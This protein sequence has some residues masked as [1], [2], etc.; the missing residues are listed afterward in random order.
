MQDPLRRILSTLLYCLNHL[1]SNRLG[2]VARPHVTRPISP[3]FLLQRGRAQN[4][5]EVLRDF[6]FFKRNRD[7]CSYRIGILCYANLFGKQHWRLGRHRLNRCHREVLCIRS[8]DKHICIN[9]RFEALSSI[10][11][12]SECR[13]FSNSQLNCKLLQ[14]LYILLFSWSSNYEVSI[15]H[16]ASDSRKSTKGKFKSF[17]RLNSTQKQQKRGILR[18]PISFSEV[19]CIRQ[20]IKL[21]KIHAI[22]D[23]KSRDIKLQLLRFSLFN[24]RGIVNGPGSFK[25][26]VSEK[27]EICLFSKPPLL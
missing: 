12:T 20:L 11:K 21:R 16:I 3:H 25:I 5:P 9:K 2:S 4:L 19:S 10:H 24:L 13:C 26:L 17:S 27:P 8:Q 15:W 7:A 23:D 1:L 6:V 22:W 14:L 18:D